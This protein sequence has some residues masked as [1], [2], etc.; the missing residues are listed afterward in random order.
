MKLIHLSDLH[1]GKRVNEFS[2]LEDQEYILKEMIDLIGREEPDGVIIAGDVYDKP[3][4]PAEAVRLFDRFLTQLA[5]MGR[6]VF[7]ISGNHDSPER[8]SFGGRLMSSRK[9]Y[10]APV[11]D[12]QVR[13]VELKDRFGSVFVYLLPYLKPASV[14][15]C[16]PE[17][18]AEIDSYD[19]AVRFALDQIRSGGE[20]DSRARNV[21]VAHQ[22]VMGASCCESEELSVGGL[23]Q[24]SAT[25]F[26]GFDYVALGHIHG[27]QKVGRET[28]RYC[29][30]PLK[31]SFSEAGHKKSMTVVS[32]EE[33][34]RVA[35]RALP[36]VPLR[37]LRE[38][39]GSYGQVTDRAF[40][41]GTA[42]E[43]YL[44]ITL[45]DEEDI[46][47]AI[48]RLRA[49][50]PNVMRLDYDNKRTRSGQTVEAAQRRQK[51]P[52]ELFA[53]LYELQNN[54]PLSPQ[55]QE[56]AGKMIEELW[57]EMP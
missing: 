15:R 3:V 30:T 47:D 53:E 46:L 41:Q 42:V 55:Q 43:D 56:L 4:P 16:F 33:K 31:Y 45:T 9:V 19:D 39:K 29:G 26:D 34:G 2:M 24:V 38:I 18:E 12:G 14:R 23:D 48:G 40:Y 52:G 7:V 25:A 32:L 13:P 10:V 36:L 44:H 6:P 5:D 17:A 35:V 49:I 22:F 21:L 57:E 1:I 27:P 20:F 51:S 11:Y 37:D 50:Y 54:Q 8:L 28:L